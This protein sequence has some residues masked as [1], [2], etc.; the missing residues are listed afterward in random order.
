MYVSI[1][2]VDD[3]A[4]GYYRAK[5]ECERLIAESGLP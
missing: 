3:A 1:V 4:L 5:L 2:G